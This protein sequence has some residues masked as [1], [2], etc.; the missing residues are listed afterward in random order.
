VHKARQAAG[1]GT[2][3]QPGVRHGVPHA[4]LLTTAAAAAA[5]AARDHAQP[6]SWRQVKAAARCVCRAEARGSIQP[7]GS[8]GSGL[9]TTG[10]LGAARCCSLSRVSLCCTWGW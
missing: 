7:W 5:A 10:E 1:P 6:L 8:F 2:L 9:R 4:G 3:L